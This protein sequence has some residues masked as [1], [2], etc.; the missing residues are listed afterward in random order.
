MKVTVHRTVTVGRL[1]ADI[2][3]RFGS[4]AALR[5]HLRRRPRDF[6][7]KV[8]LHDLREYARENPRNVVRETRQVIIPDHA[9]DQLTVQ[10]LQLLLALK[11]LAGVVPS[12]RTLARAVKRDVKNVSEDVRALQELG[13][14]DVEAR[15]R[16]KPSRIALPGDRIDL[17]LVESEA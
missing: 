4:E 16:G 2:R 11:G 6:A 7:A 9:I 14:L 17:H 1:L 15:G 12:L 13:L 8:A 5:A 10:R 3:T